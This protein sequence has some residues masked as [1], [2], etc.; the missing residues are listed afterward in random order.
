MVRVKVPRVRDKRSGKVETPEIYNRV[1]KDNYLSEKIMKRILAGISQKRYKEVAQGLANSFGLSQ[2][3]VSRI[4]TEE[5]EKYLKEFENRQLN[6][7]N[8]LAIIIDGKYLKKDQIVYAIGITSTGYKI[9]LGFIQ[10]NTENSEDI[11][12]LLKNLINRKLKYENGI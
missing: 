12:G 3:I 5:A 2:S 7:Y 11:K 10:T 4:F 6:D 8:I 9:I 1:N